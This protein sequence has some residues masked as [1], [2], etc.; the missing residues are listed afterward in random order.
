MHE[1]PSWEHI[2]G[3]QWGAKSYIIQWG[4][5][6]SRN[7]VKGCS[8][9]SK[10]CLR[11]GMRWW[12]MSTVASAFSG[13]LS[14][15]GS[16]SSMRSTKGCKFSGTLGRR[17]IFLGVETKEILWPFWAMSLAS[18]KNGPMWPN[19]SHGNT[20]MWSFSFCSA[21]DMLVFKHERVASLSWMVIFILQ[22][23]ENMNFKRDRFESIHGKLFFLYFF[24]LFICASL[25]NL[26]P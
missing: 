25:V 24:F 2:G 10:A 19:A 4:L 20:T 9:P 14:T 22:Y 11:C 3:N 1:I 5:H 16:G 17:W 23:I 13:S 15:R 21:M 7:M 6:L 26:G 12:G 18:S 8:R